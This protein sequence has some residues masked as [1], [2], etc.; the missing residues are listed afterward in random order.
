MR[1]GIDAKDIEGDR[2]GVGRYLFN[3]LKY[4]KGEDLILYFKKEAVDLPFEKR[5]LGSSSNAWHMHVALPRAAK[6]D[7]VDILFCPGYISPL[8]YSGRTA[9]TLHD[10][11]YETRPDLYRLSLSDRFFLK[12]VSR[13]SARKAEAVFVPSEYSKREVIQYYQLSPEKIF[14]T[15][16]S[17]DEAIKPVKNPDWL[18]EIGITGKFIFYYGTISD[19]RHL[20]EVMRAFEKIHGYQFLVVGKNISSFDIDGLAKEINGR[21]GREA[22]LRREFVSDEDLSVLYGSAELLVWLSEYEGYGL[23]VIEALACGVPV[24]TSPITSIPEVAGEAALYVQGFDIDEIYGKI[25]QGLTDENL[26]NSL[27]KKGFEQIKKFSWEECARK[28]LLCLKNSTPL[29]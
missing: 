28:T 16:L 6:K 3:L 24:V 13:I 5:V 8:F 4:W 9:L 19:R 12:K 20:P 26:R 21:L 1:I 23:P 27:I 17:S 25:Y 14:V 11:V 2:T 15:Y 29:G 18:R 7:K 10:I 22:I